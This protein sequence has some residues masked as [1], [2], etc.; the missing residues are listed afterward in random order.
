MTG[1]QDTPPLTRLRVACSRPVLQVLT[2][3]I[4]NDIDHAQPHQN[5]EGNQRT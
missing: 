5:A 4:R 1:Q 3:R 2:A